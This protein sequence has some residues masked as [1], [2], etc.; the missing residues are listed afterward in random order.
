M[1]RGRLRRRRLHLAEAPAF[2][3]LPQGAAPLSVTSLPQ[4]AT[5]LPD[6][7]LDR[8]ALRDYFDLLTIER[9]GNRYVEEGLALFLRR[10]RPKAPLQAV[11]AVVRA[12]GTSV[13][14]PGI[15]NET[16]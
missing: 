10:Y 12:L 13:M 8:P 5:M 15:P 6:W 1:A 9:E 4:A 7:L 11:T 2:L 3:P 14:S 16:G